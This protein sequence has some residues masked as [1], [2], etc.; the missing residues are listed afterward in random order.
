M[1]NPFVGR[2]WLAVAALGLAGGCNKQVS[3]PLAHESPDTAQLSNF[4]AEKM[5][6]SKSV[7]GMPG[8]PVELNSFYAA[9]QRLDGNAVTKQFESLRRLAPHPNVANEQG[10]LNGIAWEGVKEINCAFEFFAPGNDEFFLPLGHEII[11]SIPAGSIY[12][13]GTDFGRFLITALAKS[14]VHGD[15]FFVLTQNALVDNAYLNYLRGM[16]GDKIRLPTAEDS[17]LCFSNYISDARAR[18]EHDMQHPDEP[19]Q[20]KP[21]E[22]VH[23]DNGKIQIGG[24]I[25]VMT[26]NGLLAKDIFDNNPQREFY[27]EE[28]FPLDWMHPYLEPHGLIMKINRQ[29]LAALPADVV[30]A[31]HEFWDNRVGALL[32]TRL[33]PDTPLESVL[34]FADKVYVRKDLSGTTGNPHYFTNDYPKK[35]Y[36]KMRSSLASLY[37]WRAQNA[38]STEERERMIHEADFAYRQAW[39]LCPYSPEAIFG[40]TTFL[41]NRQ[42]KAD[43]KLLLE[44]SLSVIPARDTSGL[45]GQVSLALKSAQAE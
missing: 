38:T 8:E 14:Q 9:A 31:D 35:A 15:P 22:D 29:P 34:D 39:V 5:A 44:A 30:K 32:G 23:V 33:Q 1:K 28:S 42:K 45:E 19:R 36:S 12:F 2:L 21:G 25:A 11:D 6:Q 40:Y 41:M 17:Q 20:I 43:A 3:A 7:P 27:I 4:V 37:A 13:G 16:Y 18:Y 26:I 24:Q 10:R